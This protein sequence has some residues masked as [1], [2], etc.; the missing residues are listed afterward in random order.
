M[1]R[2]LHSHRQGPGL[3]SYD[4]VCHMVQPKKKSEG[5]K[6]FVTK[7]TLRQCVVASL[8]LSP[9]EMLPPGKKPRRWWCFFCFF[10]SVHFSPSVLSDS[11]T[12][13]TAARQASLSITNSWSLLKLMSIESVM[14]S[15]HLI[16]CHPL[17]PL[18]SIYPSIRVFSSKSVLHIRWPK[19]QLQLQHQSFR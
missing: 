17:L 3:G 19:Y 16:F 6:H 9:T 13:W 1:V 11:V 12:P 5:E 2:T 14:P 15:N 8:L 10:L 4:P 18:P 7:N